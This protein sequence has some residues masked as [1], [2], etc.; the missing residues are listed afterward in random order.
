M[1]LKMVIPAV[2]FS[3]VY[4]QTISLKEIGHKCSNASEVSC[5]CLFVFFWG[6]FVVV[7]FVFFVCLFV[8]LFVFVSF[9]L[10][11]VCCR[12]F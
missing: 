1:T 8:C 4:Y 3:D 2:Q 9:F 7:V 6:F 12:L 5:V 10:L 11:F